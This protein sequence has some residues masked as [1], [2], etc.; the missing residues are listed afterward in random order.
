LIRLK[1]VENPLYKKVA[2]AGSEVSGNPVVPIMVRGQKKRIFQDT[3]PGLFGF[4]Q[5]CDLAHYLL[6]HGVLPG[7]ADPPRGDGM[8]LLSGLQGMDRADGHV[9]GSAQLT[10]V[11]DGNPRSQ[12]RFN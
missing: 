6:D 12:V 10:D 7:P 8:P 3:A 2:L 11:P 1:T 4:D 5:P 9:N